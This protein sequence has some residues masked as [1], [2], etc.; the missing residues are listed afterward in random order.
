M[1]C[2]SPC[3][4]A[5]AT[6]IPGIS[7]GIHR[8]TTTGKPRQ[9][10]ANVRPLS[11]PGRA[12]LNYPLSRGTRFTSSPTLH[13]SRQGFADK[14]LHARVVQA[15]LS[16]GFERPFP[17]VPRLSRRTGFARHLHRQSQLPQRV[18]QLPQ[19]FHPNPFLETRC[20]VGGRNLAD[21]TGESILKDPLYLRQRQV[22][23]AQDAV[24]VGDLV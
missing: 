11:S 8:R 23:P 3:G 7:S 6:G 20:A 16:N 19:G 18:D 22:C 15:Q 17:A 9:I 13:S 12:R 2:G 21:R 24:Q 5:D 10:G 14:R 1:G 4:T